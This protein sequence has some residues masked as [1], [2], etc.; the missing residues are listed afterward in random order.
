MTLTGVCFEYD[1]ATDIDPKT[2]KCPQLTNV[3]PCS[4]NYCDGTKDDGKKACCGDGC[5][6]HRDLNTGTSNC[7]CKSRSPS[8]PDSWCYANAPCPCDWLNCGCTLNLPTLDPV[9]RPQLQCKDAKGDPGGICPAF[10]NACCSGGV[11][12]EACYESST[13][14]CCTMGT[15]KGHVCP[16]GRC[17]T[18]PGFICD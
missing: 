3:C 2:G 4:T 15:A 9:A 5:P 17:S 10:D 6:T 13:Q 16:K 7:T 8:V 1:C 14:D 18:K 11:S 12:G